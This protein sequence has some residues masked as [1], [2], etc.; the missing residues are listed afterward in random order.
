[1][2]IVSKLCLIVSQ[3]E[4]YSD[5]GIDVLG[6]DYALK[7]DD[8][9]VDELLDVFKGCLEVLTRNGVVLARTHLRG[10]APFEDE[11]AGDLSSS[12]DWERLIER[13]CSR[14]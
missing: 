2:G 9:E 12:D 8:E 14:D 3:I 5:C 6:E 7:L 4:A 13:C 1:M 11:L 10:E